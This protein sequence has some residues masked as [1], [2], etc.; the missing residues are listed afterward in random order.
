MEP[1]EEKYQDVLHNMETALVQ[2][3]REHDEMMDWDALTA[4]NGHIRTY[5]S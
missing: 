3:Y 5:T 4:V 2:A 1:F